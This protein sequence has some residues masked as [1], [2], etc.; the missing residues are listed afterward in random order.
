V[1]KD[2]K[3]GLDEAFLKGCQRLKPSLSK[4]IIRAEHGRRQCWEIAF[5]N[6]E[7]EGERGASSL[8]LEP[9]G[10]RLCSGAE[11]FDWRRHGY[12]HVVHVV[13]GAIEVSNYTP[14]SFT[15]GSS[16]PFIGHCLLPSYFTS[17]PLDS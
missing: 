3:T 10:Q 15:Q 14:S 17:L 9:R 7:N 8:E 13:I 4:K 5:P 11:A 1:H 2:Q 12:N 6:R 16:L